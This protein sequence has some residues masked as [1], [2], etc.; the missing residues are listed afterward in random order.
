MR[1]RLR[2]SRR[3][4]YIILL[5]YTHQNLGHGH[6]QMRFATAITIYS[7]KKVSV[8]GILHWLTGGDKV[9]TYYVEKEPLG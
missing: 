1:L 3:R 7:R 2:R 9:L 8:G 4:A 6:N 5:N